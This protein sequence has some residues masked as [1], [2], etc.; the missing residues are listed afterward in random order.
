M[1]SDNGES[2]R[3]T[4]LQL[5]DKL[6]IGTHDEQERTFE[7]LALF[8][9]DEGHK[10]AVCCCDE[11]SELIVTDAFGALATDPELVEEIIADFKDF[12]EE[13]APPQR[14]E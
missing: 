11:K 1:A 3:E 5:G 14:T 8:E 2:P 10:Y 12:A 13:A 7:V 6:L 4:P 9:D